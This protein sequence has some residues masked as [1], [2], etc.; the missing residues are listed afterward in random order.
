[1]PRQGE[2]HVSDNAEQTGHNVIHGA[3]QEK[4]RENPNSPIGTKT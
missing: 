4:V 3:E 1:M 2:G